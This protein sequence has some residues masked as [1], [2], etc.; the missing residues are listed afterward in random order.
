MA[1]FPLMVGGLAL[2]G[3]LLG[4]LPDV[5]GALNGRKASY[6]VICHTKTCKN[7]QSTLLCTHTVEA[8]KFMQG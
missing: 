6:L 8:K 1:G 2:G 3:A 4:V 5:V 7:Y